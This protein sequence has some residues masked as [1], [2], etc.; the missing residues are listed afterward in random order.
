MKRRKEKTE[1]ENAERTDGGK[2]DQMKSREQVEE[3]KANNLD[4]L[5]MWKDCEYEECRTNNSNS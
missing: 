5:G 4:H 1:Q 3:T 2:Q